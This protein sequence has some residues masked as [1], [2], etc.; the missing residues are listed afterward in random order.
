MDTRNEDTIV[1]QIERNLSNHMNDSLFL[2][3]RASDHSRSAAENNKLAM[4]HTMTVYQPEKADQE[5]MTEVTQQE[6]PLVSNEYISNMTGISRAEYIRQARESCL[7]QLSNTQLY[8]RPYD[9][10][11]IDTEPAANEQLNK[12]KAKVMKLFHTGTEETSPEEEM[13]TPEEM[14]S[15]RSLVIRGVLAIMLF[16]CIFAFDKFNLKIGDLTNSMIKEYVTGNDALKDLENI[17]VTWLK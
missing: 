2:N 4:N 8:S 10:N 11:Y 6:L 13:S 7:R 17:L 16:L 5:K 15:Y 14:A 9:V 12:K 3:G 1:H